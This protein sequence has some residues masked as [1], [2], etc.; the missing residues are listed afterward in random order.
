MA[1]LQ[2][3]RTVVNH[4]TGNKSEKVIIQ[5]EHRSHLAL[6]KIYDLLLDN[7]AL[8]GG[9]KILYKRGRKTSIQYRLC[10]ICATRAI[11]GDKLVHCAVCKTKSNTPT[12]VVAPLSTEDYAKYYKY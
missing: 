3:T 4:S 12:N 6:Y 8:E 7:Q 11:E 2:I 5:A 9:D 1:S 10:M